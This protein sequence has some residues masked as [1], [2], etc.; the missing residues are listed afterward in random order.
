MTEAARKPQLPK[1]PVGAGQSWEAGSGRGSDSNWH[2]GEKQRNK[3]R[4]FIDRWAHNQKKATC[5]QNRDTYK[6]VMDMN[7]NNKT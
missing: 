6:R 4:N 2:E 3:E 5:V 1:G 7:I